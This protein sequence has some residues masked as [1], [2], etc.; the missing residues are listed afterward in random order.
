MYLFVFV[1]VLVHVHIHTY[2][3]VCILYILYACTREFF[4][5]LLHTIHVVR[6]VGSRF[7][8][9]ASTDTYYQVDSTPSRRVAVAW[10]VIFLYVVFL[11][12]LAVGSGESQF[13]NLDLN[14]PGIK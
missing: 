3:Y 11:Y 2:M 1:Y 4:Q 6:P 12:F 8:T 13:Q 14:K 5:F 10:L 7:L 9:C